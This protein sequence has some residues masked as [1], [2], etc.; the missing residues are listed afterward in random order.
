MVMID[1]GSST[2]QSHGYSAVHYLSE[3]DLALVGRL[4]KQSALSP[5]VG[6]WVPSMWANQEDIWPEHVARTQSGVKSLA[7]T[8]RIRKHCR[9]AFYSNRTRTAD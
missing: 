6:L 7:R 3:A 1:N 2:V 5:T 4:L 8:K 9:H